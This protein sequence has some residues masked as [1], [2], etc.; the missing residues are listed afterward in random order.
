MI[1]KKVKRY[2]CEHPGCKKSGGAAWAMRYHEARCTANPNRVC[3]MCEM[4]D[5]GTETLQELIAVLPEPVGWGECDG[6]PTGELYKG[7]HRQA[8]EGLKRLQELTECPACI[9]AAIRQRGI[10]GYCD[11]DFKK[12][13]DEM[14]TNIRDAD[15]ENRSLAS[16][17][18]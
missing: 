3:G 1:T 13:R 10:A 5:G 6:D 16:T 17:W 2:Y 18:L 15:A 11:F 9:L 7:W 14:F 8:A 12:E 4:C